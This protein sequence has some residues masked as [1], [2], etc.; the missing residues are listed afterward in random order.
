MQLG[1]GLGE[2]LF[3]EVTDTLLTSLEVKVQKPRLDSTHVLSDMACMGRARMIGVAL[4]RFIKKVRQHDAA[5]P[6]IVDRL[7]GA[8]SGLTRFEYADMGVR[9]VSLPY[10]GLPSPSQP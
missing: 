1:E 3:Q 5:L 10:D 6:K 4:R 8:S 7:T 2:K 9:R